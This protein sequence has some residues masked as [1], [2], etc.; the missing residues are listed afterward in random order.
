MDPQYPIG[1]FTAPGTIT[2]AEREQWI[3]EIENLP[4]ELRRVVESLPEGALEKHYRPGGWT[5]RQV[6]H[7]VADSHVNSYVRFRLAL[8][9]ETPT[10][11]PYDE[12][13]WAELPDAKSGHVEVSL[14]LLE[15]I[16]GRW[17]TL[18]RSLSDEQWSRRF[19]HPEMGERDLGVTLALYAWHG[20]HHLAQLRLLE[21]AQ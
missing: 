4:V 18:L 16:H 9:E 19:R 14:R 8:T 20:R 12:G 15:A 5:G 11:K 3:R 13:A 17:A 1:R 2:G 21:S 10:I 7:H 6:V